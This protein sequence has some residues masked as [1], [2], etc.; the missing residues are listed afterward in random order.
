MSS[1]EHIIK[2]DSINGV[3]QG[4]YMLMRIECYGLDGYPYKDEIVCHSVSEGA[5]IDYCHENRL[6]LY[7]NAGGWADYFITRHD[8]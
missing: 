3:P 8:K 2:Y 6:R 5:L 4:H 1:D 7:E